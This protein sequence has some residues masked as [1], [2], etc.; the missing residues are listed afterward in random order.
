MYL[1]TRGHQIRYP[2]PAHPNEL[3]GVGSL[4]RLGVV[5]TVCLCS[6]G[7]EGVSAG[8]GEPVGQ[9]RGQKMG[10]PWEGRES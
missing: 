9:R 1:G 2:V 7:T 6:S 4:F 10:Q 5:D 8:A 3:S